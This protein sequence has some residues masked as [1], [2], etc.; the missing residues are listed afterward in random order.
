MDPIGVMHMNAFVDF[1]GESMMSMPTHWIILFAFAF[2]L[3]IVI[4]R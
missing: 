1:D 3:S 4:T 2:T